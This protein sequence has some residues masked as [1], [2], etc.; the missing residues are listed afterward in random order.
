LRD[1]TQQDQLVSI[2]GPYGFFFYVELC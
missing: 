2:V 1:T